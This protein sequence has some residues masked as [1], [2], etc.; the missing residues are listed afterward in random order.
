MLAAKP[1]PED[2]D[3][4]LPTLR[5]PLL[6]SPKLDGIRAT[7][8]NGKLYSR[9]LKLIPNKQMQNA[10][11]TKD[12]NGLDGEIVV[13]PPTAEDCFNRSTSVVMSR[14]KSMEG[15]RFYVF[16]SLDDVE[17][18]S[19]RVNN[20]S[21][22]ANQ[23]GFLNLQGVI[24]SSER[25]ITPVEHTLLK[26]IQQL[27]KY[28]EKCLKQG[29]EGIMLRDQNGAYKQGRST[30]KEGGL[31]AVK[32][33][34][35][36]EAVVLDTYEQEENTNEKTINELGRSKRSTHKAGKVGKDTLGGFVV[37]LCIKDGD[38]ACN[39]LFNKP[40][41]CHPEF[42]IGTGQ[43]LTDALR[44]ELWGKR[45]GLVGQIIKFRYQKIG[46]MVAP[47]QPIFLGFRDP[48]DL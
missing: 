38:R 22:T 3:N 13:G 43:G 35:D 27:L 24:A 41:V 34:V 19:I 6:G 31:I 48:K 46:T 29:Y 20:A 25:W 33:F 23:R 4:I 5:F 40:C 10:W 30:L 42:N 16:D 37:R 17:P 12:L 15:A 45:K 28:E 9:S 21:L 26:N 39:Y 2:I 18:F 44:K 47:R 7:V 32:R 14:D 11:G 8:Q 1:D 36:A